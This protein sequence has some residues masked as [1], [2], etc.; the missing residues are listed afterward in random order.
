MI[1]LPC[2]FPGYSREHFLGPV[3]GR[4][5]AVRTGASSKWSVQHGNDFSRGPQGGLLGFAF[6]WHRVT[7]AG[8]PHGSNP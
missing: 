4:P 5:L 2:W 6:R 1:L 8:G 7:P 3:S